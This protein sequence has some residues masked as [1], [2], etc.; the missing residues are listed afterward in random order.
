MIKQWEYC[1]LGL[2][3]TNTDVEQ[4][5]G[6]PRS[7]FVN[8][9]NTVQFLVKRISEGSESLPKHNLFTCY[10]TDLERFGFHDDMMEPDYI[11]EERLRLFLENYL[12]VFTPLRKAT[13]SSDVYLAKDIE[14]LRKADTFQWDA[15]YVPVPVYS[16]EKHK[17]TFQE[18]CDKLLNRK[19][20]GKIER[21]STDSSDTPRY[22]LWKESETE[23]Y[24]IGPFASHSYAH[25]GFCFH[26]A[27]PLKVHTLA[28]AWLDDMYEVYQSIQF[29]NIHQFDTLDQLMQ[30]PEARELEQAPQVVTELEAAASLV[31][32][33]DPPA[34]ALDA[35]YTQ[36]EENEFLSRF[37]RVTRE[38]GLLYAERDL[39]NFHNA[40]KTSNL[41]ILQGMSGIGKTQLIQAYAKALGLEAH[42]QL[43]V[44]PVRP[45]WT[46]D[47]DILGYV[48]S[49]NMIYRPSETGLVD[50]L[51][52]AAKAENQESKLYIIA[53]DEM[54]LARV[55]HYFSQFLSVLE[56][57]GQERLL[58]LYNE[59]LTSK[60]YNA[61]QYPASVTIGDNVMFVGTVNLDES[62]YHFS[63]K[64]LDRAN[65]I[66]LEVLRYSLLAQVEEAADCLPVQPVHYKKYRSF[67]SQDGKLQLSQQELDLLWELHEAMHEADA[68]TGIGPRIV[69]QIDSY[70]KNLPD[71]PYITRGEALDLQL[72]QRILSKL[73]GPED[74]WKPVVGVYEESGHVGASRLL[75]ILQAYSTLSSFEKTI[76]V[77]KQKARELKYNGYMY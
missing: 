13:P 64:V 14:L 29:M 11:R 7:V 28:E 42:K 52:E 27:A 32:L 19:Y 10:A 70:M 21:I 63:D 49:L 50:V 36:N 4:E 41:V 72:T 39:V 2:L 77:L 54:N 46:D 12:L 1:L 31:V 73:R 53:F 62:T 5:L 71:T 43:L 25:G 65:V 30:D 38:C 40:M 23:L 3:A 60:L 33:P 58:R 15:P 45:S 24:V 55:E 56:T 9:Q 47:A 51:I 34:P 61:S 16:K 67:Y 74:I 18:F 26:A 20:V 44:I 76:R 75:Q 8:K 17:C 22:I 66:T 69:R 59:G 35:A 6:K 37:I 48:D 68:R 57:D